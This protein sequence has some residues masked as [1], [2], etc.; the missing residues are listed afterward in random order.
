MAGLLHGVRVLVVEDHEDNRLMLAES[1]SVQGASVE[2]VS[3]ADAAVN[4]L[5]RCDVI[6]TDFALPDHDGAWLLEQ[7]TNHARCVPVILLSGYAERQRKDISSA[8]FARKLLKPID[9]LQLG[10][11]IVRTLGLTQRPSSA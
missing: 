7:T 1:L 3:T 4:A 8:P 10:L 9:P 6:V 5:D 11:E 2:S